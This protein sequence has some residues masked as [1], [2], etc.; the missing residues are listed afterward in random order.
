MNTRMNRGRLNVG[1]YFLRPY[2]CSER[3]V[4]E[5]AECGIDFV[6]CLQYDVPTLDLFTK[7]NVGAVVT[8]TLFYVSVFF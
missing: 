6:V 7:Y 1:T 3:H 2:A 8:V 4:K 5:L